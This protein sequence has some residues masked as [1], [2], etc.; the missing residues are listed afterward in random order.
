MA[1]LLIGATILIT[2][3]GLL[4]AFVPLKLRL[5][6]SGISDIAAITACYFVGFLAGAWWNER[7]IRAV[8]HIRAYGGLI[9][10]VVLATLSL[11]L[12]RDP[13]SWI[14]M[15]FL[16]GMAA[17]GAFLAIE[18]WLTAA[19]NGPDRGRMLA[20]Y[21]VCTLAALGGS[22]FLVGI[23]NIGSSDLIILAGMIY[24][25]SIFPVMLTRIAAPEIEPSPPLSLGNVFRVSPFAVVASFAAGVTLGGFWA[26]GPLYG[27]QQG[28]EPHQVSTLMASAIFAGLVLQW[29]AARLSDLIDRRIVVLGL[30]V[31][32]TVMALSMLIPWVGRIVPIYVP[33]GVIGSTFCLYPLAVAHGIDNASGGVNTLQVSRGL[34]LANGL[35]LA[36]GPFAAGECAVIWG[37]PGLMIFFAMV[38]GS[39]ALVTAIRMVTRRSPPSDQKEPFVF[40]R[41]NTPA[42]A[43]IDPRNSATIASNT[44]GQPATN[45]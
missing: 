40:V 13:E 26:L 24:A 6:G 8:G 12:M 45:S 42:G 3:Q 36:I 33:F 4:L 22:Q 18:S 32:C 20:A 28:L 9:A 39:V 1:T 25:A 21:T 15:R 43:V 29:P 30:T 23:Y 31:A 27:A 17:G 34:L 38:L 35:G 7:V 5:M 14:A 41:T 11:G 44:D 2:G 19:A 37:G 16:H 10:I